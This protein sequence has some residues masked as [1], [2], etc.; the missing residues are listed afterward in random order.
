[1]TPTRGLVA[2]GEGA[3]RIVGRYAEVT[4]AGARMRFSDRCDGTLL[5]VTRGTV[6]FRDL[7]GTTTT[8]IGPGGQRLAGP[9]ES[10]LHGTPG[11]TNAARPVRIPGYPGPL[12]VCTNLGRGCRTLT[13]TTLVRIGSFL[14]TRRGAVSLETGRDAAT[15]A[16]AATGRTRRIVVYGGIVQLRQARAPKAI[17]KA[18]LAGGNFTRACGGVPASGAAVG[19]LVL[20]SPRYKKRVVRRAKATGEGP[21]EF[22]GRDARAITTGTNFLVSDRCDGTF[23]CVTKGAVDVRDDRRQHRTTVRAPGSTMVPRP[24]R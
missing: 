1:M 11:L 16:L 19:R 24:G 17:L 21:F 7:A 20:R 9:P 3:L 6:Q 23:V 22:D 15:R 13:R 2:D 12:K 4:T 8:T 14:D 18:R 5:R 10:G